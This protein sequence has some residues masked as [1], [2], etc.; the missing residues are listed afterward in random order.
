ML[1][2]RGDIPDCDSAVTIQYPPEMLLTWPGNQ[3][4]KILIGTKLCSLDSEEDLN[5]RIGM[6]TRRLSCQS[7]TSS[8]ILTYFSFFAI[9]LKRAM[10][11]MGPVRWPNRWADFQI[12]Y[13]LVRYYLFGFQMGHCG[14]M[15]GVGWIWLISRVDD[16]I[17]VC[18]NADPNVSFNVDLNFVL[19][20]VSQN[21]AGRGDVCKQH[22]D[23]LISFKVFIRVCHKKMI[24]TCCHSDGIRRI[25]WLA[26]QI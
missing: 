2:W 7:R 10:I 16:Q 19:F 14:V 26:E 17:V 1:P 11:F 21:H 18:Q 24:C 22:L 6:V 25:V 23:S 12:P 4:R 5:L 15:S 9:A 8:K 13:G 3:T 20:R